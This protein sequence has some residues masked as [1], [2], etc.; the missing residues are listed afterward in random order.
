M[1][2]YPL[3]PGVRPGTT[4]ETAGEAAAFVARYSTGMCR[5]VLDLLSD[6]PA[7]PEELQTKLQARRE[8]RVLLTTVR[9]RVC[10]LRAQGLVV[11]EGSRGMGESGKVR[12]IRWRLATP[13]ETLAFLAMKE[14]AA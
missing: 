14:A 9:A 7:T 12:V 1:K 3:E 10:Q 5:D 8:G 4:G 11:D 13:A 2:G 6:G